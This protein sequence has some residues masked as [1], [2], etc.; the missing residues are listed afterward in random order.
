M[1]TNENADACSQVE[2]LHWNPAL[3]QSKGSRVRWLGLGF[4]LESSG[5]GDLETVKFCIYNL[6]LGGYES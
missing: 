5:F 6:G 4:S 2:A 1:E 3:V